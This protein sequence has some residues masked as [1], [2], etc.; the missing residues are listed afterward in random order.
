M[1]TSQ[2]CKIR[3]VKTVAF[4]CKFPAYILSRAEEPEGSQMKE[5]RIS[6]EQHS[7]NT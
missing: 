7:I 4:Q 1:D 3:R 5:P 6:N 2:I